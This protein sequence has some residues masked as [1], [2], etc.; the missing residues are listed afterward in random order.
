MKRAE[1]R[2]NKVA[3]SAEP[4]P[5]TVVAA[6]EAKFRA[7][8]TYVGTLEPWVAA[9]VGPQLVSAYVDTVLVRPGAT[10]KRGDVLATLD[11]KSASAAQQAV[12]MQAR[13]VE[14]RQQALADESARISSLL[15]GGFVSKNEAEQKQAQSMAEEAQLLATKAQLM[16]TALEV[17]DCV[18]RAPFDG[19][20]SSRT[21]DPGAFVRPGTAIVAIVDRSTIRLT[22]DAPEIDFD[23]VPAGTPV[24]VRAFATNKQLTGTVARRTPSADPST[25]T[26]HFEIDLPDPAR[27]I[28]VN[29]TGEIRVEVGDPMPATELPLSAASIR[30]EK[31]TVF[32]VED[33]VA[34]SKTLVAKGELGGSVFVD[35]ALAPGTLVV[36][37]GRGLLSDGDR[38]QAKTVESPGSKP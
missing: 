10:V 37:E 4:K 28:P 38:V 11:C 6:K 26:V 21:V 19:E 8:R 20:V 33:G 31:A 34:H 2:T 13:A 18:L 15:D 5:V 24:S 16:G 32:I 22:A 29:T 27:E 30:G 36:T 14:Q 25:R 9:S 1:S 35:A 23:V 12:A 7:S 3:L 17:N